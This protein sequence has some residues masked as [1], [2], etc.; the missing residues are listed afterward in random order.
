[1]PFW[2]DILKHEK[3]HLLTALLY[4]Q[5]QKIIPIQTA[6]EYTKEPT[7]TNIEMLIMASLF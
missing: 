7:N 4:T 1:M 6:D 2:I 5:S 3:S